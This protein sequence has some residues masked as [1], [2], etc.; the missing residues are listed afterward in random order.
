MT[1][2]Q[3][4]DEAMTLFMAG[5][6][7]TANH[8]GVDLVPPVAA[9]RRRGAAPRRARRPSSA[10]VCPTFADLRHLVRTPSGS[11]PR[12]CGSI[13]PSGCSAARRSSRC[14]I[15]GWRVPVG[16]TLYMS[17]WV[18][19]RDARRFFDDP[20]SVPPRARLGRRG[21]RGASPATP[22]SP[23]AAARGSASATASRRWKRVL[24]LA[25]LLLRVRLEMAGPDPTPFPSITL[26]PEGGPVM[27]V[28]V[29]GAS[30]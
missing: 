22:T 4:R 13:R 9:P 1:D 20:E 3:L 2:R 8:A 6:E 26:R 19:H 15:G 23:S 25:T 27:R 24:L 18:L 29:R 28:R 10:A 14:T 12:L 5:H 7:T 21:A 17:Q 11:S 16:M 30:G